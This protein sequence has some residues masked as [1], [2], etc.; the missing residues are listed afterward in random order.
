MARRWITHPGL[1]VKILVKVADVGL[2]GIRIV[3]IYTWPANADIESDDGR[4]TYVRRQS[5]R[6]RQPRPWTGPEVFEH[7]GQFGNMDDIYPLSSPQAL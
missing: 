6:V 4:E 2:E 1:K 7:F 3:S 5:Y